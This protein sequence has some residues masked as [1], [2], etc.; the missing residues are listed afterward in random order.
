MPKFVKRY[1]DLG[2]GIEK[3]IK[4]YAGGGPLAGLPGG[5]TMSIGMKAKKP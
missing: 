3:A 4:G 5:R 2:P 1:G